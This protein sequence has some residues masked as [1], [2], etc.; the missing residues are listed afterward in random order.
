MA[1]QPSQEPEKKSI[2]D[3]ITPQTKPETPDTLSR[4][5]VEPKD[6]SSLRRRLTPA[7]MSGAKPIDNGQ[8]AQK[9]GAT[10]GEKERPRLT[11]AQG[12]S[13]P[14]NPLG[15]KQKADTTKVSL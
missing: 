15:N 12:G 9:N 7:G 14:S 10:E 11:P 8:P 13:A 1:S 3:K 5:A 4:Q 6:S 2:K